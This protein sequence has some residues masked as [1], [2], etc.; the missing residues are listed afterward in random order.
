MKRPATRIKELKEELR[1][2]QGHVRMETRWLK[3]SKNKA[4]EI[5]KVMREIQKEIL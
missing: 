4:K 5:G 3:A 2:W 1:Y